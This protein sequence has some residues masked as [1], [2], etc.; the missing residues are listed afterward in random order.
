MRRVGWVG[1]WIACAL[2]GCGDDG[3]DGGGTAGTQSDASIAGSS[4]GG[5]RAGSGGGAA[6]GSGGGGRA[7]NGAAGRGGGAGSAG[8]APIDRDGGTGDAATS[9]GGL[10]EPA[11]CT[12][13]APID[14]GVSWA[15]TLHVAMNGADS[16]D[17]SEGS[18]FASID[19]ALSDAEP[20]T[21]VLVHAGTYGP[22][23]AGD[24]RGE[25]QRPIGIIADGEVVLEARGAQ[26]IIGMS[27]PA[28]VVIEGFTLQGATVHGMNIDDGGSYDTPAHHIVL[29]DLTIPGAGSGGNNDCIKLSGVDD[30]WV[31]GSDV[32]GCDR[33]EIIDMVG[34]HRGVIAG[35]YFH[36]TI[37]NGVQAKGGSADTL[38][39]GNRFERIPARAVNA[40]GST[41]LEF[42]RPLDAPH[43]AARIRVIANV[44][45]QNG[46][47]SGAAI[48]YVGCD[49]C[50]AAHN[51]IIEPRSW[52][53]RILQ[54]STDARFVPSRN[55]L[56]VNNIVVLTPG[57]LRAELVNVG[58]DTAPETFTFGNNLWFA[59]GEGAGWAPVL[60]GSI[61]DETGS[62]AQ[63]DPRMVDRGRGDYRL[64]ADSPALGAARALDPDAPADFDG[65]CYE[66][67]AALGA[68][69]GQ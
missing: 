58:A 30:F 62:L 17:G 67:P 11:D 40:G 16:G 14:R 7:G 44:F 45:V 35:N 49:G 50:V 41:G 15:R 2:L 60:S 38:I 51:T 13:P 3:A 47:M 1:A 56:F 43:E 46:A 69:E 53:A 66:D 39:H 18:P 23:S 29:R 10:P 63:I 37:Q 55:G 6:G 59:L 4:G 36:D 31:L 22:V 32:A 54:E 8:S 28:Y 9:D 65:R 25:P 61:P 20:G 52:V 57:D 21:R 34:C 24:V 5:G 12:L 68:F 64:M 19:R 33:G 48:A 42:F 26:A 27:D